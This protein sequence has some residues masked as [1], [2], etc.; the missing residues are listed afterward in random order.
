[1][2]QYKFLKRGCI[3]I[4]KILVV[5][6]SLTARNLLKRSLKNSNYEVVAEA[7]SGEKAI[8]QY[9]TYKPDIVTMDLDMPGI[10][11]IEAAK[12][13]LAAYPDAKIVLVT[14][15]EQ[16]DLSKLPDQ[17]IF[18]YIISKPVNGAAVLCTFEK[19]IEE[20]KQGNRLKKDSIR[21]NIQYR[22]EDTE[23]I[24][25]QNKSIQI[26]IEEDYFD[27]D[28][29][30]E[31]STKLAVNDIVAVNHYS[32]SNYFMGS[33][34][35]SDENTLVL[36]IDPA[37][38][39]SNFFEND[40]IVIGYKN[41]DKCFISSYR[42]LS[43]N[44]KNRTVKIK[45]NFIHNLIVKSLTEKYPISSYVDG[46]EIISNKKFSAAI[47]NIN[48]NQMTIY[49]RNEFEIGEKLEFYMPVFENIA[50]IKADVIEKHTRSQGFEYKISINYSNFDNNR[51]VLQWFL[52]TLIEQDLRNII[53]L[54]DKYTT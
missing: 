41:E 24:P 53:S 7:E 36:K 23:Q 12:R 48:I 21:E 8:A 10:G 33:V 11:G 18:K 2:I 3:I 22:K 49:S 5:D 39:I 34:E 15:H 40:P 54:M 43:M 47:R 45:F 6:D 51:K 29:D 32:K 46:K 19:V 30:G 52:N 28:I 26:E 44:I 31:Q 50:N 20:K 13:I 9:T 17:N 1:M 14:A 4:A 38:N 16:N 37:V 35:K 42:I 25:E 27:V